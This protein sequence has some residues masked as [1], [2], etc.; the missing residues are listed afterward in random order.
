KQ[1]EVRCVFK[2]SFKISQDSDFIVHQ[3][4]ICEDVYSYQHEDG[5]GPDRQNLAFDLANGLKTPW[6]AKILDLLLK[7]LQNR[8]VQ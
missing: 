4:A 8:C 6:N 7:E 3:P 2:D 1:G 5:P